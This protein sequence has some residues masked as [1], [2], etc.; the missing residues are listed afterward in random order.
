MVSRIMLWPSRASRP[1][2]V[3]LSTPPL[4]A[5]AMVFAGMGGCQGRNFSEMGDGVHY[6]VN[7]GVDLLLGVGSTERKPD[8]GARAL[9]SQAD[10]EEHVRGLDRSARAR[11]S[12]RNRES[13]EVE[14]NDKGLAF[15]IIEVQIRGIRDARGLA[16]VDAR[17][18]YAGQD[19]RFQAVAQSSQS[20]GL[21]VAM[22][23]H[24]AG[25]RAQRDG[26]GDILCTRAAVG[27]VM[28]AVQDPADP[29]AL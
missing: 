21:S 16:A 2:T 23:R 20:G 10:R 25:C 13:A 15:Q 24:R 9:R 14:R 8:T 27:P 5:T 1:A 4:M 26:S 7:Q 3:E 11:R 6:S 19:A 29:H 12:A 18:R 22:A 28:A 17:V